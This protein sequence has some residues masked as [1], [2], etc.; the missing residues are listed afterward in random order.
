M[1]GN[2]I[3]NQQVKRYMES[4]KQ[5]H[6][7][8]VS[9]AKSGIS[10]RSGR[11]IERGKRTLQ[12]AERHWR[13][14]KDPLEEAWK[15]VLVPLLEKTPHLQ[16]ITLLEYLQDQYP[17]QYED[18]VL[19]TLQ[20]RVKE[21]RAIY[22]PDKEVMFRQQHLAGQ[23]GLSDFTQLKKTTIT[24]AGQSFSHLLYHFRLIYS[25]WSFMK[26]IVGGESYTALAEGLQEALQRLGGAPLEH[27]TDSLSAAYKNLS[28]DEQSDM[29]KRYQSL[30]DH[31]AMKATRNNRGRGHE[32][33]GVESPHG[34]LKRR[35]EQ[36][37]LLRGNH[38][39]ES[40]ITYQ[41]FIDDVV[42]H[43]NNRNA[44]TITLERP[45]LQQLPQSI[46]VD[47]REVRAVVSSSST[48]DVRKVTYTV[49]SRLQ[50][51]TLN[52]RLYDDRLLCYLGRQQIITLSRTYPIGK[53]NR[54]K[55]VDYRHV[56]HSLVKKPQAFRYSQIRDELLPSS[57][58]HLIWQHV[59]HAM[60]PREACKFIVGLLYLSAT[61]N[62]E[63]TLAHAVLK[64]IDVGKPLSLIRLQ[65]RFKTHTE[66]KTPNIKIEQHLLANYNALIPVLRGVC[67]V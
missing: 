39:F 22:G 26:V 63:S 45:S 59:D 53:N 8:A 46:A 23:Q 14:R 25:K 32:N 67:H 31:Y 34:H 48:I 37:L 21:W 4:R 64:D 6:T 41:A 17:E 40:M 36:A 51:E 20:R 60:Q 55:Q 11:D 12:T 7:Q 9:A 52:I 13:T 28:K 49:P 27:R 43:H 3:S 62:C 29:T 50:G 18:K 35:I 44:K 24:I 57:A 58:Y 30:C 33:G 16:A 19:R 61:E 66:I 15:S 56:I 42:R 54:A 5:G 47:Y 65:A 1:S 2:R 10:V 38:D